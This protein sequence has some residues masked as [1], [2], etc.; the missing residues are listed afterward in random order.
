MSQNKIHGA[1]ITPLADTEI[2]LQ[3]LLDEKLSESSTAHYFGVLQCSDAFVWGLWDNNSWKWAYEAAPN[4]IRKPCRATLMEA[5]IFSDDEEILLWRTGNFDDEKFCGRTVKDLEDCEPD[6]KPIE[7][8]AKFVGTGTR[9]GDF[10]VR[11]QSGGAVTVTPPGNE[12]IMKQYLQEDEDT[13]AL[14]IALT[15][16]VNISGE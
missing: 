4:Q 11:V 3:W 9:V 10:V 8:R 7:Q 2:V 1:E 13:G 5:R 6:Y 15:R 16:F 12:I 14:R